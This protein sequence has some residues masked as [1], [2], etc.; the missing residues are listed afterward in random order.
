MA[1]A[2]LTK[3]SASRKRS[4]IK[5]ARYRKLATTIK[6][7]SETRAKD[8]DL[9]A[10]WRALK[11]IGAYETKESPALKRLT[12][13]RRESIRKKFNDV[14]SLAK[15]DNGEAYRPF[16][17][18]KKLKNVVIRNDLGQTK[19]KYVRESS[20]Y[21]LDRDHFQLLRSKKK[22]DIPNSLKTAKGKLIAKAANE[23]ISITKNGAI[24]R[25]QITENAKTEFTRIPLSGP[26]DFINLV[27]DIRSGKLELKKGE[28]LSLS[29]NGQRP[30]LYYAG[31]L[32]R[33]TEKL[34]FYM[35]PGALIRKGGSPGDFDDWANNAEIVK[36]YRR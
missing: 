17:K 35:R 16:H 26:I 19:R 33:L 21:K 23:K 25:T 34:E 11:S 27:E 6:K 20:S 4:E 28:A 36:T 15:Y 8:K 2:N 30:Q 22:A 14:Q 3:L 7:Q 29:S 10:Q 9:V 18:V 5:A 24:R 12:K 1:K 32:A 13:S 31:T